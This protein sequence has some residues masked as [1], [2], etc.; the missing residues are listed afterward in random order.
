MKV[1]A[2]VLTLNEE[3]SITRCLDSLVW[4]EKVVVLDSFSSDGTCDLASSKGAAVVK[5]KFDNYAAQRNFGLNEIEYPTEW[6]LMVDADEVVSSNLRDEILALADEISASICIYRMRRKDFFLGQWLRRSSGYPT[7]FGRLVRLGRVKVEREINE[8]YVT[9]GKIELLN[10]HLHHF[11]FSKGMAWWFERHNRY[12]SMEAER[13]FLETVGR[14]EGPAPGIG[15]LFNR[16]PTVK[17][18]FLKH[19]LYR[20]PGRP[21]IVFFYLYVFRLGFLDGAAGFRYSVMRTFYEYQISCKILEKR[22]LQKGL[23]I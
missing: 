9:D 5:R 16:D 4:C 8:E 3:A 23:S 13:I 7:W 14:V 17:R 15:D 11:P 1:S 2:L 10:E 19:W 20:T 18:R 22:R 21:L 6:V 12:S